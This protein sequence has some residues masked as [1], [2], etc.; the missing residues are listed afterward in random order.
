MLTESTHLDIY[1]TDTVKESISTNTQKRK[2]D[3]ILSHEATKVKQKIIK[4]IIALTKGLLFHLDNKT[5][6]KGPLFIAD[7]HIFTYFKYY[8]L[9]SLNI[10]AYSL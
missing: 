6:R 3:Y 4:N 10:I 8:T 1:W 9:Q 2:L 5:Y 7:V